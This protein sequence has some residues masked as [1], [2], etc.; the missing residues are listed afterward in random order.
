MLYNGSDVIRDLEW[1][2]F[3]EIHYINDAD[4]SFFFFFVSVNFIGITSLKYR[5]F[6]WRIL[7]NKRFGSDSLKSFSYLQQINQS[8]AHV[9]NFRLKVL[10]QRQK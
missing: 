5:R 7:R 2:I 1:V 3:D 9:D 10:H 6:L 8:L 4:V